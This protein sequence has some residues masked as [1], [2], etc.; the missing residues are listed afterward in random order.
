[1]YTWSNHKYKNTLTVATKIR[2]L[3]FLSDQK[4]LSGKRFFRYFGMLNVNEFHT[5]KN[6]EKFYHEANSSTWV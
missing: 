4:Y 3:S 5:E 1:M 6:Y 2:V